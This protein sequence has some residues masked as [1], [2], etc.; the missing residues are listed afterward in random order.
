MRKHIYR[1]RYNFTAIGVC[2][3]RYGRS[4]Y[5]YIYKY[6]LGSTL[7]YWLTDPETPPKQMTATHCILRVVICIPDHIWKWPNYISLCYISVCSPAETGHTNTHICPG[8]RA[9]DWPHVLSAASAP[10]V[11]TACVT[12][13]WHLILVGER[14]S[15]EPTHGRAHTRAQIN[16][17]KE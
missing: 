12:P 1:Q 5:V 4:M 13:R 11:T 10:W 15:H 17:K 7:V 8:R 9:T 14:H 16:Q 2:D 3:G 6:S